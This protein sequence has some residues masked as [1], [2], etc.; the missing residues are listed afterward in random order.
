VIAMP[1]AASLIGKTAESLAHRVR[2]VSS[3]IETATTVR[4]DDA[5]LARTMLRTIR[6]DLDAMT[7]TEL[8]EGERR[9]LVWIAREAQDDE[10]LMRAFDHD[11]EALQVLQSATAKLAA[12]LPEND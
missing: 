4:R 3:L 8:T 11:P 12:T 2:S 6:A 1:N 9:I 7:Q 5:R 10:Y